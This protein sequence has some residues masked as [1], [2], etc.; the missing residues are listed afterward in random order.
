VLLHPVL[1][2]SVTRPGGPVPSVSC[3][4]SATGSPPV[5]RR[6]GEDTLRSATLPSP[7]GRSVS[8]CA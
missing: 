3:P 5:S 7:G 1:L 4:R 8:W 2:L 6:R